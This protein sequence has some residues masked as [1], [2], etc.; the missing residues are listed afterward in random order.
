MSPRL[1]FA[2]TGIIVVG[3]G[4]RIESAELR[5]SGIGLLVAA[6]LLRFVKDRKGD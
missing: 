1:A 3:I 4:I 2:V 5:W 6:L